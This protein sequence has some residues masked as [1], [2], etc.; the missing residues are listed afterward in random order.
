MKLTYWIANRESDSHCYSIRERTKKAAQAKLAEWGSND[1][2]GPLHKVTIEY[3]DAFK[4]MI[5]CTDE[6]ASGQY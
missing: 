3:A 5:S 4:L 6:C 2:F 1:D